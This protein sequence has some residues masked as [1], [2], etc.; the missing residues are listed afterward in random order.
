MSQK[1]VRDADGDLVNIG[2]MWDA[3]LY[4]Q[5]QE[6]AGVIE[7]Y[8]HNGTRTESEQRHLQRA[9]QYLEDLSEEYDSRED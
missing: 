7:H 4:R 1:W 6:A 3:K 5:A 9:Q 2:E 8:Q